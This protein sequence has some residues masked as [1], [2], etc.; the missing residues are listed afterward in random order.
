MLENGLN[1]AVLRYF[2]AALAKDDTKEYNSVFS[3]GLALALA[4]SALF[5]LF[6]WIF[7]PQL[8]HLFKKIPAD[9]EAVAT[10]TLP[11]HILSSCLNAFILP[12][13]LAVF[14]S[15][16]RF[17]ICAIIRTGM[18]SVQVIAWF[19]V[20]GL[21]DYGF[22]G[23][24]YSNLAVNAVFVLLAI[25]FSKSFFRPLHFNAIL[26]R[27]K[28]VYELCSASTKLFIIKLSIFSL[29]DVYPFLFSSFGSM[30]MNTVFQ[31][32][33]KSSGLIVTIVG[34]ASS[35]FLPHL[36][37]SF[38]RNDFDRIKRIY[39]DSCRVIFSFV[40]AATV[41]SVFYSDYLFYLWLGRAMPENWLYTSKIFSWFVI[42]LAF[43]S[44]ASIQYHILFA[45]NKMNSLT[46]FYTVR[47]ALTVAASVYLLTH[48]DLG[49]FTI[50]VINLPAA[51]F[52]VLFMMRV[53]KKYIGAGVCDQ[54]KFT[55]A[56]GVITAAILCPAAY[57]LKNYLTPDMDVIFKLAYNLAIM[58][59]L[60]ALVLWR[61]GFSA[62][63]KERIL[64]MGILKK[65]DGI[66]SALSQ[67][68]PFF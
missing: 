28:T 63:D 37:D 48:T 49:V 7:A 3:T 30:T 35:Q 18:Q 57:C 44:T 27:I 16:N 10:S 33:S 31:S 1:S 5:L 64:R 15:K 22:T 38:V 54:L 66:L 17:D 20:L 61:I 13:F 67:K 6:S 43:S 56:R 39:Y 36:T 53:L 11:V 47:M 29:S 2:S 60:S 68:C 26:V 4:A 12:I 45:L 19:T 51:L 46:V 41:L 25:G 42:I 21:T 58:C 32:A 24:V 55:Y 40:S 14:A 34:N 59:P 9:L 50:V 8:I 23:W 62:H 52:T 65:F